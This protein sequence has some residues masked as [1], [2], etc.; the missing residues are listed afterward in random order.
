[1][2]FHAHNSVLYEEFA[3][4][5]ERG[6]RVLEDRKELLHLADMAVGSLHAQAET[7]DTG[8]PCAHVAKLSDVLC[9]QEQVGVVSIQ[10][11]QR[12]PRLDGKRDGFSGRSAPV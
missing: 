11:Y 4:Q 10:R 8:G 12:A 3:P 1:M 7:I 2:N 5:G 9:R 6:H